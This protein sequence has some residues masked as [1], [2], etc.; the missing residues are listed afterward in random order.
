LQLGATDAVN[1]DGGSSSSQISGNTLINRP[2]T[3]DQ[4]SSNGFP[5]HNAIVFTTNAK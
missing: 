1:L 4:E 5:I 2:R 3:N